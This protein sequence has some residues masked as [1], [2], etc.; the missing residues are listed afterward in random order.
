[1]I[2]PRAA[3]LDAVPVPPLDLT[4]ILDGLGPSAQCGQRR[5]GPPGAPPPSCT[6]PDPFG[7]V[8]CR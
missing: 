8:V 3:L 1:V 4:L 2:T 5:L 7:V 6:A